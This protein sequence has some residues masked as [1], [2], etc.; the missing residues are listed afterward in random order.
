MFID[1]SAFVAIFCKEPEAGLFAARIERA[2]QRRT[3]PMVRL[4]TCIV[5]ASR[6]DRDPVDVQED[7]DA[8]LAEAG[9]A[10]VPIDDAIGRI[11]VAAFRRFGKGRGHPA[12]LNLAD[13]LSYACACAYG[14]PILFKGRDFGHTDLTSAL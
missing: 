6:L 9:I 2:D 5:L 12:Q 1:T 13:C 11:A 3:S 14:D 8:F 4:E 10:V 7:V